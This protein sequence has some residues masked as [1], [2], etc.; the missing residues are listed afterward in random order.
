MRLPSPVISLLARLAPW[1]LPVAAFASMVELIGGG[2]D[3]QWH[4]AHVPEFFWTPPH[5]VLYSGAGLVLLS[6]AGAFLLPWAGRP[7]AGP[8]RSATTI[9]FAGAV[10]Q[11]AA[12]GLDSAWHA[13]F[14]ADDTLS[15]PHV[16]LTGAMVIT[17]FGIVLSLHA[18]R[19]T[20]PMEGP[21]RTVA[22]LA[23]AVGVT[24][25]T[26]AT[27]GLLF[28]LLFPGLFRTD[29]LLRPFGLR[30]FTAAAFATLF[31]LMVLTS[32]R[33]VRRRGAATASAATQLGGF[34]LI[35]GL[36]GSLNPATLPYSALFLVPGVLADLLYRPAGRGSAYVAIA[37]GA[38]VAQFAFIT[39]GVVDDMTRPDQI[40]V[41]AALAYI[42]G[43]VIAA[44]LAERIGEIAEGLGEEPASPVPVAA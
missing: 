21:R 32:A 24:A 40:L 13:A 35:E 23:H 31:P 8:V 37:L 6:T 3:I 20:E 11:F 41:A 18:W 25:M 22:W 4:I 7:V 36:M 27:W 14:G 34:L 39:G 10:L 33:V 43:G 44:L 26:W 16:F 9:A 42:A 29:I 17:S 12:G 30:L 5:I 2:W 38:L 1:L 15:P 28:I 19:R